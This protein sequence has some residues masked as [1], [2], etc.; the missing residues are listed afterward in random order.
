M[1][2][3]LLSGGDSGER[4]V[5]LTSG[6]AV[7][8]A[9]SELGH[10][11]YAIDPT[12]GR[13]LLGEDGTFVGYTADT[14]SSDRTKE[15]ET[16]TLARVLESDE[17]RDVDI[18]FIALHGGAG[19]N[20]SIQ[21]LLE[22]AGVAYTGSDKTASAVAMDKA[23]SKRLFESENIPTSDWELYKLSGDSTDDHLCKMISERF[24]YPIIVKP[25]DGGSTIGLS[26]V[27]SDEELHPAI[28]KAFAESRDILV[29]KFIPG[30]E[31]TVAVLDGRAFPV[32]E[33]KPKSGLYDYE[34]KYTEGKSEYIVPAP[35]T[36]EI[37]DRIKKAAVKVFKVIGATGLARVDFIL[38]N[39]DR[40]YCLELN[41]VPGMT[42]LSLAPMAANADGIDFN[43]L[44]TAVI[45]SGIKRVTR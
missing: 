32:V 19:E 21:N 35:I 42:R 30:R 9:L 28:V 24:I 29:E 15:S 22:L 38:D 20:G 23:L 41:S 26:K 33:I 44:M 14:A 45:E 8:S 37:T 36:Q 43:Q 34:A 40:F 31:L 17:L 16:L 10:T 2:I 5:S 27:V 13:S 18:V 12:T 11:V 25:N 39:A 3:L 1:K 6:K 4:D 7:F